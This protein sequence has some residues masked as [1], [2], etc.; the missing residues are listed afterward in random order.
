MAI[1]QPDFV[2]EEIFESAKAAMAKKKPGLDTERAR[3][4]KFTEGL[5]VQAMHIGPYDDEPATIAAMEGFAAEN[6]Y[7]VDID[8]TRRHHEIYLADPRK[9]PPEKLKTVLRHPIR[10]V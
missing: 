3:L 5:C 7:A 10:R 1:R 6:G 8:D 4:M 9:V 2:T